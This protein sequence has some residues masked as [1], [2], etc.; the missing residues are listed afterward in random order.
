MSTSLEHEIERLQDGGHA[1][2]VRGW[3]EDGRYALV[4]YNGEGYV[5]SR[6]TANGIGRWEAPAHVLRDHAELYAQ[7]F[8]HRDDPT[9][10]EA[11]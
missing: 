6:R 1:V 4:I 7:R 5:A 11:T 3:S 9:E 2:Y 8:P 10:S